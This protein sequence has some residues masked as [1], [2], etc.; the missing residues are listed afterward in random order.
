MHD[1]KKIKYRLEDFELP[2]KRELPALH[3]DIATY[4]DCI[5]KITERQF[6]PYLSELKQKMMD[7]AKQRKA[8]HP[9]QF[10]SFFRIYVV[11]HRLHIPVVLLDPEGSEANW[12]WKFAKHDREF[13]EYVYGDGEIFGPDILQGRWNVQFLK[14]FIKQ[15]GFA[16]IEELAMPSLLVFANESLEER[17][18]LAPWQVNCMLMKYRESNLVDWDAILSNGSLT[19]DYMKSLKDFD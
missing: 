7:Y 2:I 16:P 5:L 17:R 6:P 1:D 4:C 9:R 3:Y 15:Y 19:T 13:E 10:E 12:C 18:T 11:D 8:T 14:S